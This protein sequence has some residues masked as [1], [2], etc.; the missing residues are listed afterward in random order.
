MDFSCGFDCGPGIGQWILLLGI[1]SAG[2]A[3]GRQRRW[4]LWLSLPA[5]L[6]T[7]GW[8]FADTWE[9]LSERLIALAICLAPLLSL[10]R[11]RRN[12]DSP[13]PT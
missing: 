10:V 12:E 9:P 13:A 2:F 7:F 11:R 6:A 1:A 4:S 3:A 8:M 5:A